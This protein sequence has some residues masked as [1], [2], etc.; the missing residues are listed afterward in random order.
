MDI[1][2][3]LLSR[4]AALLSEAR[5]IVERVRSKAGD[6]DNL[7][8]ADEEPLDGLLKITNDIDHTIAAIDKFTKED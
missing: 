6:A 1:D 8:I 2:R 7:S 3:K 5:D 4:V